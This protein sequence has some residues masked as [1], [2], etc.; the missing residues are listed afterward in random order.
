MLTLIISLVMCPSASD[1]RSQADWDGAEGQSRA[2]LLSEMSTS[3][4]PS[5][6]IPEHRLATLLTLVQEEQI[7]KC[8]YHNTDDQPSL[9]TDHECPA[10]DFPL[11]TEIELQHHSDEV[12]YLE[13]S[14]DGTM[15]ATAG[16]DGLVCVYDTVRWR[17]KHEFREHERSALG[18]S[19]NQTGSAADNRGVCYVAFSPDDQYL[20][21]CSQ[22]NEFVVVNVRNGQRVGH[23][24]F[25]YPVTTAAWLPDSQT[26]V[27]GTQGSEKTLSLYSL[28]PSASD[29]SRVGGSSSSSV[30]S[31]E[32][33][34][35]RHPPRDPDPALKDR[36]PRSYRIT[37]CAVNADGT[38][39][40]AT[41]IDNHIM[42][43]SLDP[44][45]RYPKLTEWSM[46]NKL[47]SISFSGDGRLILVNMNEGHVLALNADSGEIVCRYKGAV[48]KEYVIRSAFGGAGEGFVVSGSEGKF[49]LY[50][51]ERDI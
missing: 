17:L 21:S 35:W 14:H 6:M 48:Q 28:R 37:D 10:D 24:R 42:V 47:T 38:R 39:M 51:K 23:D 13:F 45:A 43:Y 46:E 40:V 41:T 27:V 9:Y 4:S 34:S 26:F 5:V 49:W 22:N 33:H 50:R 7:F 44:I 15:L 16:K 1:L 12:W 30:R 19:T 8:R 3:I 2:I 25:D 11:H 31:T 29:S 20:V 32:I 18:S 36:P